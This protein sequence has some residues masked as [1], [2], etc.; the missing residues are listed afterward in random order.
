[1]KAL[2]LSLVMVVFGFGQFACAC[3]ALS[4]HT[5]T[6]VKNTGVHHHDHTAGALKSDARRAAP[7]SHHHDGDSDHCQQTTLASN[8]TTSGLTV[9]PPNANSVVIPAPRASVA[10]V[11]A[12]VTSNLPRTWLDPPIRT[13]IALK[14]KNLN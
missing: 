14:V 6:T 11:V 8:G 10:F 3:D 1:M 12:V 5:A 9:A 13:P 7:L 4:S 2:I